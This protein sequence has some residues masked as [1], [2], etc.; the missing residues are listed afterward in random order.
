[1][2][3][4][5]VLNC[6]WLIVQLSVFYEI[7]RSRAFSML[8]WLWTYPYRAYG[9]SYSLGITANTCT[10]TITSNRSG[11]RGNES[12]R[13]ST[14]YLLYCLKLHVLIK[15][16]GRINQNC[17]IYVRHNSHFFGLSS[18]PVENPGSL[19]TDSFLWRLYTIHICTKYFVSENTL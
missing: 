8:C 11:N 2:S 4:P 3:R 12:T 13:G 6:A 10:C 16:M 7:E 17:S 18:F 19:S 9:L 14:L 5:N 15:P 1:M